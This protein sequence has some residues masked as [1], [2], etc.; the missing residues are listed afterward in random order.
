MHYK[1]DIKDVGW[2]GQNIIMFLYDWSVIS[3]KDVQ[4]LKD[5][6]PWNSSLCVHVESQNLHLYLSHTPFLSHL[7]RSLLRRSHPVGIVIRRGSLF[8]FCRVGLPLADPTSPPVG[9]TPSA[10]PP[11]AWPPWCLPAIVCILILYKHSTLYL[12][13]NCIYFQPNTHIFYQVL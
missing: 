7:S 10:T 2:E 13:P 5:F 6:F 3:Y 12:L 1:L 4:N 9:S 11:P 8:L